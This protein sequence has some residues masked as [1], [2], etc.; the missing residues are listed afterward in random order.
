MNENY[1]EI[2]ELKRINSY[3]I[4]LAGAGLAAERQKHEVRR[5][6]GHLRASV[7]KLAKLCQGTDEGVVREFEKLELIITSGAIWKLDTPVNCPFFH[8]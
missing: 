3:L 5:M 6:L 7:K 4:Q 1:E 8:A 2:V